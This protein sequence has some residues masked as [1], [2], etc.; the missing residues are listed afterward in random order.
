LKPETKPASVLQPV[1]AESPAWQ[2]RPSEDAQ[3]PVP[4][5]VVEIHIGR[6]EVRAALPSMPPK[7]TAQKA[8]MSLEEYLRK[9][10]GEKQ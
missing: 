9:R 7:R 6:V 3:A 4:Q 1:P 2:V 5:Q 10:P 8:T